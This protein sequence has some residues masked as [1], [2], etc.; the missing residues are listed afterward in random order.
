MTSTATDVTQTQRTVAFVRDF[1]RYPK[2]SANANPRFDV[3]LSSGMRVRTGVDSAFAYEIEDAFR[4]G[5]RYSFV[6][7]AHGTIVGMEEVRS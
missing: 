6:I 2:L 3:V 4:S 1:R 5:A 7:D